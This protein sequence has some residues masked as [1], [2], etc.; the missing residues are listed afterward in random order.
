MPTYGGNYDNVKVRVA[1][2]G[3]IRGTAHNHETVNRILTRLKEGQFFSNF[4][5]KGKW[6]SFMMSYKRRGN[7]GLMFFRRSLIFNISLTI[8]CAMIRKAL[9][10]CLL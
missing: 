5:P 10:D 4:F 2:L 6:Q 1:C 7:R 3:I 9:F 8:G